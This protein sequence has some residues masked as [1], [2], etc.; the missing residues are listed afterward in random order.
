MGGN[1]LASFG[2][3]AGAIVWGWL[4][5]VSVAQW[6]FVLVTKHLA[7]RTS[8]TV[9]NFNLDFLGCFCNTERW[10]VT[11][12][13]DIFG[14]VMLA[15]LLEEASSGKHCWTPFSFVAMLFGGFV[16]GGLLPGESFGSSR[17]ACLGLDPVLSD[18]GR[19]F[20]STNPS[21]R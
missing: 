11:R 7:R 13:E 21:L 10:L 19:V 9:P 3:V 12:K 20:G 15:W 2:L 8:E 17:A 14:R 5:S 18:H 6:A 16:Y 4:G 1:V